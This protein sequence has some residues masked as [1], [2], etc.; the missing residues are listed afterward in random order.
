MSL[1]AGFDF[2]SEISNATIL[3]LIK[4][5][6]TIQGVPASPPFQIE[7]PISSSGISGS[8]SLIVK[9]LT[10]DLNSDN[11]LSLNLQFHKTSVMIT[12]PLTRDICPVDG[13]IT[14][15]TPLLLV[16]AGSNKKRVA[17]DLPSATVTINFSSAADTIIQT[18][19]AG[20]PITL[21]QFKDFAT[22][23]FTAFVHGMGQNVLPL[24]FT[25]VANVDGSLSPLQFERLE[26]K[27][28][29]NLDKSKQALCLLGIILKAN[30][31]NGT[32]G[33]KTASAI[34]PG[35]D[36]CISISPGTFHSLIFCPGLASALGASVSNLPGT[37]GPAAGFNKDG[38]T[39]TSLSDSFGQDHLDINGSVSKS[40]TCYDATG[41][42]HGTIALSISG[43]T[44]TPAV[45]L[46]DP[47]IDVDIPWYCWLAAGLILGPLGLVITGVV[48]AVA[49][50]VANSMASAAVKGALG[51]NLQGVDVGGLG[52]ASFKEVKITPAGLTLQGEAPYITIPAPMTQKFWLTG[53]VTTLSKNVV[54][55]GVYHANVS[56]CGIDKDYPYTE[57]AQQ[58]SG[59][60]A[61]HASLLTPPLDLHWEI[62]VP[63]PG[64]LGADVYP[65]TGASGTI[66][67]SA[68]TD[69]PLPLPGGSSV[70]QVI[71]I[72]YKISGNTVTLTNQPSE[73]NYSFPLYVTG[74]DCSGI[75]LEAED[76]FIFH[77]EAVEMGGGYNEDM[78]ACFAAIS[79][80][81][82]EHSKIAAKR[83]FPPDLISP[84]N[85][86]P[87][88]EMVRS[89]YELVSLDLHEADVLLLDMKLAHGISYYR[90]L[91]S[92]AASQVGL[93]PQARAGISAKARVGMAPADIST[94][95]IAISATTAQ[96][97]AG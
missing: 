10:I 50:D 13:T 80:W 64:G 20:L 42:F 97:S 77:G 54:S 87:P 17:A 82:R 75:S 59:V 91:Y 31:A 88:D 48:N 30:H 29:G 24:E 27:C 9:D 43:S 53:S 44:L 96:E 78:A 56:P 72:G 85:Y 22:Q 93:S 66:S 81:L 70:S 62:R 90:G 73:G 1:L 63:K 8:A 3:K 55:S 5:N 52:G 23:A 84:V 16:S 19:L 58:Q 67:F 12:S 36:L 94:L 89:I 11:S 2:A 47:D 71:H 65:L 95:V 51:N 92:S 39:V 34:G 18:A 6:L 74:T 7:V 57:Y 60:Y 40:G 45:Q 61:V 49:E 37:C 46:D 83:K 76:W 26:L 33:Q 14:I 69:Y 79:Q 38:V 32:P 21:A 15:K 35:R 86:P 25:V 68:K 28:I 41:T 4:A